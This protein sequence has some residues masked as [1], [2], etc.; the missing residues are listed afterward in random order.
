MSGETTISPGRGRVAGKVAIVTG[1]A[2]A[3]APRRAPGVPPR[4]R[5]PAKVPRCWLR[6]SDLVNAD[7]TVNDIREAGGEASSCVVDVARS[8]QCTA[9]VDTAVERY[10]ALHVLIKQ[11]RLCP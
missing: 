5:S 9:M 2:P 7:R 1:A 4:W 11:R 10:G 6:I 8:E 3:R